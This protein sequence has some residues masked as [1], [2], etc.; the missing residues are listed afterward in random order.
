MV[1]TS[2]NLIGCIEISNVLR[3]AFPPTLALPVKVDSV[4]VFLFQY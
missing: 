4:S 2:A 1:H 3:S